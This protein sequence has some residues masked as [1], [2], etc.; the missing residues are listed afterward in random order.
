MTTDVCI[1]ECFKRLGTTPILCMDRSERSVKILILIVSI[2]PTSLKS[3]FDQGF[4]SVELTHP[5]EFFPDD[6]R[7]VLIGVEFCN[8]V[9]LDGCLIVAAETNQ[10]LGQSL[11]KFYIRRLKPDG[12]GEFTGKLIEVVDLTLIEWFVTCRAE[13]TLF[14]GCRFDD[15]V[16]KL[17]LRR[18][19]TL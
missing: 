8:R 6:V 4:R 9:A 12:S 13:E 7:R 11:A 16:G 2:A 15:H 18:F 10:Q 17:P 1:S 14:T 3:F 5:V 19:L